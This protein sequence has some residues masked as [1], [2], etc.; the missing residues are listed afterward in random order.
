MSPADFLTWFA[1]GSIIVLA[2][3]TLRQW[4]RWRDRSSLDIVFVFGSLAGLMILEGS[5]RLASAEPAWL[6]PLGVSVLLAHPYLLLRV[7]SHFRPIS[8]TFRRLAPVGLVLALGV[9]WLPVR[10]FHTL[11]MAAY[12][13]CYFIGLLAFDAYAFM[14]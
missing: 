14:A 8:A 13:F 3:L 9:V 5:M 2:A 6:R 12:A 4:M 7:V 10:P 11:G 1:Q